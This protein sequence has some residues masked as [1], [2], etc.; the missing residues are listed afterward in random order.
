MV[1]QLQQLHQNMVLLVEEAVELL[2]EMVQ[3]VMVVS[4]A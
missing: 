4:V 3:I 2:V 1:V